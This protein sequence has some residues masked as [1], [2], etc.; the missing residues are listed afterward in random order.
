MKKPALSSILV[1][2]LVLALGVIAEAQQ[3]GKLARIG[4]LDPSTAS[5]SAVLWDAFRQEMRKFGWVEGKNIVIEYRFAEQKP[6]RLP[7]LAAELV[8]FNVDLIVAQTRPR[9]W[10]RRTRVLP[11][12]L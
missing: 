8:R 9:R 5:G 4:I 7:E 10:R 11:Y 3:T 1:A 6:N 2:T 12:R